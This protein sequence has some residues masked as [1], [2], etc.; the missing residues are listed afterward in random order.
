MVDPHDD[1]LA[2]LGH[3]NR[4]EFERTL[5]RWSG[6][7]GAVEERSGVLT[8]ASA[9][10]FPVL[11]N[12]A[13]ALDPTLPGDAVVRE[14][15]AR[16]EALGRGFC[17]PLRDLHP[18]DEPI[19]A[20]AVDAGMVALSGA[21]EMAVVE[22]VEER[23]AG[24]G[25]ELRWL[26]GGSAAAPGSAAE[27]ADFVAVSDAAYQS[28]GMPAGTLHTAVAAPHLIDTPGTTVV[29]ATVD[30]T[31]A[32]AAMALLS[33]G[34][35]GVYFVGTLEA[36]RGRGIGD[37]VTRAVTNRAFDEGARAVTLQASQMGEAIYARMG[38][39]ELFR[40]TTYVRFPPA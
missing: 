7:A 17:T 12:G 32:G 40:Y 33:H 38:Y 16:F 37:L 19:R 23:A 20:A 34:I 4:L 5:A 28:L 11:L 30:G 1:E 18:D 3:L 13:A 31:P 27:A 36:A 15:T 24:D 29:V 8:W 25:V 35:A 22:R 9:S 26:D 14:A 10:D 39:R 2:A 21:P 6:A